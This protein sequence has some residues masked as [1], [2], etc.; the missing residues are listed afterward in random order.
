LTKNDSAKLALNFHFNP[1]VNR[2]I[3][4]KTMIPL[5]VL[6]LLLAVAA[7]FAQE[8]AISTTADNTSYEASQADTV[9]YDQPVTYYSSVVYQSAVVYNA[10]VYYINAASAAAVDY[11][12]QQQCQS[13]AA[14]QPPQ[15]ASVVHVIGGSQGSYTYANYGTPPCANSVVIQVGHRGGWGISSR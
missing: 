9:V 4:M 13:A 12:N 1:D 2:V 10:P 8:D 14:C 3:A 7:A 6:L 5:Q 11:A 15:P